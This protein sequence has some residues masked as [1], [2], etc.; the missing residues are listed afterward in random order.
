MRSMT[1]GADGERPVS[2]PSVACGDTSPWRGR[3]GR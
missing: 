1:E 2:S 3:I